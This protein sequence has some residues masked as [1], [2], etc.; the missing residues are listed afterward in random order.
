MRGPKLKKGNFIMEARFKLEV[1]AQAVIIGV[2]VD[3]AELRKRINDIHEKARIKRSITLT[4]LLGCDPVVSVDGGGTDLTL[5]RVTFE[6]EGRMQSLLEAQPA[7]DR[8]A[9]LAA[10]EGEHPE[11]V[12]RVKV[13]L[14]LE[15]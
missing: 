13:A 8:Q 15:K 9:V 5:H 1:V 3:T 4:E 6:V 7:V 14:G 10:V 11:V 12:L 2:S